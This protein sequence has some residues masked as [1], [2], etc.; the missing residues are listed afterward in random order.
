MLLALRTWHVL[1]SS[2]SLCSLVIHLCNQLT[3][4]FWTDLPSLRQKYAFN[5]TKASQRPF[6]DRNISL[7]LVT[8]NVFICCPLSF[9]CF[10]PR[11]AWQGSLGCPAGLPNVKLMWIQRGAIC[12]HSQIHNDWS[13]VFSLRSSVLNLQRWFCSSTLG[14]MSITRWTPPLWGIRL[15]PC[16]DHWLR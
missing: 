4:T 14:C 7:V 5:T 9:A 2:A 11:W 10:L 13:L 1:C 6:G 8:L 12:L 3:H 15:M 16:A